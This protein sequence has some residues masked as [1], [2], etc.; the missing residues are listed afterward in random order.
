MITLENGVDERSVD[1]PAL[2]LK[3]LRTFLAPLFQRGT[4]FAGPDKCVERQARDAMRMT[5][6]EQCCAQR[7]GRNAVD[8]E[9]LHAAGTADVVGR[10]SQ[11]V[12]AIG[13]VARNV[14]VL[15]GSP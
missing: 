12:G 3:K 14:A 13:D 10:G 8:E 7:A 4:S 15:V 6:C 9:I 1:W 2:C 11:I 5:L